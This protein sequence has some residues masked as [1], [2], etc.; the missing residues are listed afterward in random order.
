MPQENQSQRLS[1]RMVDEVMARAR[2]EDVMQRRGVA[3]KKSGGELVGVCPFHDDQSPS[4]RVDPQ[5]NLWNCSPCRQS[6]RLRGGDG[7]AIGFVIKL[8]GLHFREAVKALAEE[9]GVPI[10]YEAASQQ[11]DNRMH[12]VATYEYTDAAGVVLGVKE[13][14]EHRP[15]RGREKR[16]I[17]RHPDGAPGKPKPWTPT[18]YR[19]VEVA[20]AVRARRPVLVVEGEKCADAVNAVGVVATTSEEVSSWCDAHAEHLRGAR[21][22]VLADNDKAGRGHAAN[23]LRSLKS[24]ADARPLDL[25][26]LREKEDV[27][28]W[29]ASHTADEL[30]ALIDNALVGAP[31]NDDDDT[32]AAALESARIDLI[33]AGVG[34]RDAA[35]AQRKLGAASSAARLASQ[36]RQP[37]PWLIRGVM[38]KGSVVVLGGEP[39]TSKTWTALELAMATATGSPAFGEFQTAGACS[40]AVFLAEDDEVATWNRLRSLA[41][42]RDLDAVSACARLYVENRPVLDVRNVD[43]LAWIVA[44]CRQYVAPLGLVVLD[45]LRDIIGDANE[46]SAS[47]MAPV[48]KNLRALRDVLGCAVVFVHHAGKANENSGRRRPGQRLRGSS[49]IHGAVDGGLYLNDVR[50]DLTNEWI[51]KATTEVRAARGAGSFTLTLNVDDDDN[52]EAVRAAWKVTRDGAANAET[53]EAAAALETE[54]LA[55]LRTMRDSADDPA[56]YFGADPIRDAVGCNRGPVVDALMSLLQQRKVERSVSG[57]MAKR[58]WRLAPVHPSAPDSHPSRECSPVHPSTPVLRVEGAGVGCEPRARATRDES[59]AGAAAA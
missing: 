55:A 45:P 44:T 20:A 40:A 31:A 8:E 56:R 10:E 24:V 6:G 54:V 28:D 59:G 35:P 47:E 38:T 57:S 12:V 53:D 23:V 3:L 43:D 46:D 48:M 32:E 4:L 26:G 39:K 29:L 52:G 7:T 36:P 19:L 18:L 41:A 21:V 49:G 30:R 14:L 51:N 9:I 5:G 33:A 58:G 1:K 15:R 17:W 27:A 37:T 50:G 11:A 25:P 16:F 42:S 34:V 13:R 22:L 2:V